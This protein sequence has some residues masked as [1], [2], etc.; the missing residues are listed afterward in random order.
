LSSLVLDWLL[1]FDQ[2]KIFMLSFSGFYL[3]CVM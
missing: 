2:V 3:R 1:L